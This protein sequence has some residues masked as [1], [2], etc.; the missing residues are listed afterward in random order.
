[1]KRVPYRPEKRELR[2]LA[3]LHSLPLIISEHAPAGWRK[4]D[5]L[6]LERFSSA[7]NN[8]VRERL[9]AWLERGTRIGLAIIGIGPERVSVGVFVRERPRRR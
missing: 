7:K 1:M 2:S 9:H 5:E 3:L 8:S 6:V 4:L